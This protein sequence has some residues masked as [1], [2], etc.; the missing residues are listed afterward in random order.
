MSCQV[1]HHNQHLGIGVLPQPTFRGCS[2]DSTQAYDS[3]HL[4]SGLFVVSN[5][6][7]FF[8]IL[9]IALWTCTQLHVPS[10][11]TVE[12]LRG[13]EL[14]PLSIMRL[15]TKH[16]LGLQFLSLHWRDGQ[17]LQMLEQYEELWHISALPL[18][19]ISSLSA[20]FLFHNN[21]VSKCLLKEWSEFTVDC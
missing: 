8:S 4:D 12:T 18:T 14:A 7:N 3:S 13:F 17:L 15:F 19:K 10:L 1:S 5:S 9:A 6:V 2:V 20:H 21:P 11:P 16:S